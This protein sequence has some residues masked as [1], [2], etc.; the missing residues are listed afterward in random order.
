MFTSNGSSRVSGLDSIG[1]I[2]VATDFSERGERAIRRAA[3][4]AS[5]FSADLIL[6]HVV[7]GNQPDHLVRGMEG[8]AITELDATA[9]ALKKS[10]GIACS[11]RVTRGDAFDAIVAMSKDSAAHLIVMGSHRKELLKDVF[12][13]TTL[14]RV[15]RTQAAPVLVVNSDSLSRYRSV[16]AA[17]DF[18]DCS[19][20]ALATARALGLL[21]GARVTIVHISNPSEHVRTGMPESDVGAE[22]AAGSMRASR[23]LMRFVSGLDL[24]DLDYSLRVR[25]VDGPPGMGIA[26]V[27]AELGTHLAIVGTQGRN[28][29][30]KMLL[31][32]V[33]D[34]L[35]KT[36]GSDILVVPCHPG[37]AAN[38]AATP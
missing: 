29:A 12:I 14:E 6:A 17:I 1:Q 28:R 35:L 7:E 23:E 24:R 33:T 19:G 34:D 22:I 8:L 32:S 9:R 26:G 13:G 2:L 30:I 37:G 27:A 20:Q 21:A 11:A 38:P 36:L 15:V 5:E 25:P 4:L 16:L 31:G 18:S 10:H 3:L